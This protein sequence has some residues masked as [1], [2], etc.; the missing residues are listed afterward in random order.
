ML[1]SQVFI[2]FCVS[3]INRP[4][5]RGSSSASVFCVYVEVILEFVARSTVH[6]VLGELVVRTREPENGTPNESRVGT[7][8]RLVEQRLLLQTATRYTLANWVYHRDDY[9]GHCLT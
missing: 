4:P 7:I 5:P 1:N 6:N 9:L 8:K 3:G 2:L